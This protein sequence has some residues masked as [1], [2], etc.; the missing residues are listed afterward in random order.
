MARLKKPIDYV[1]ALRLSSDPEARRLGET[2]H[3][4]RLQW[5][6]S[7][8]LEDLLQFMQSIQK[9]KERVGVAQLFGKF[10][11]Y[12]PEEFVYRL[13][14]AKVSISKS[15]DVYWGEKCLI[16]RKD[17]QQHGM[18]MDI[19]VG[20]KLNK[21]IEPTVTVDAKVEL[22]ASRLKTALASFLL[23]KKRYSHVKCFLVY[24]I[25]EVHPLLPKLMEPWID[26][27]YQFSLD[28]DE[29]TAFVKSVQEAVKQEKPSLFSLQRS[30]L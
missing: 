17:S 7:L 2:L 25:G 1:N 3:R 9:N 23:L 11:A 10:R 6:K 19:I 26:G 13:I 30:A 16:W 20:R 4:Q 24:M 15:L 8:R 28:K 18:E 22:D 14:Q 29:T 27:I 5:T 21:F 12:S